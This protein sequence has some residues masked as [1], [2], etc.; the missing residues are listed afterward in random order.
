MVPEL[1]S[2][3]YSILYKD[4]LSNS[5]KD[6]LAT[7]KYKPDKRT[8]KTLKTNAKDALTIN[9]KNKAITMSRPSKVVEVAVM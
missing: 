3:V 6:R 5:A 7:A 8:V 2:T 9:E 1:V 4:S